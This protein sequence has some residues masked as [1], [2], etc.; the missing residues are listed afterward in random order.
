MTVIRALKH[1]I[2]SVLL[3]DETKL[4]IVNPDVHLETKNQKISG[5][6]STLKYSWIVVKEICTNEKS[7]FSCNYDKITH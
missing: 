4:R 5:D 6:S 1:K 3:K 7:D 2:A